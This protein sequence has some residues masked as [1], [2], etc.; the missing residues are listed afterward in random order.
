MKQLLRSTVASAL[1]FALLACSPDQAET[2][3]LEHIER[4]LE[5]GQE[6]GFDSYMSVEAEG[7]NRFELEG[8]DASERRLEVTFDLDGQV[9]E[10]E[11]KRDSDRKRGLTDAEILQAA[12]SARDRGM[13]RF[14]EIE[15][16]DDG[17][18]EIEGR[19]DTGAELDLKLD[20]GDLSV[21]ET[22]RD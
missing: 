18:I 9:L 6:Y 14:E 8:W 5:M 11:S 19:T 3:P 15:L 4:V 21:P 16:D 17:D 20:R 7:D 22:A 13:V 10:E 2:L 12:A 1:L